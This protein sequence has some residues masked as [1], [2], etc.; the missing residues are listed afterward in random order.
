MR[1]AD[2]FWFRLGPAERAVIERNSTRRTYAAGDYLCHQG[3]RSRHVLVVRSGNVRVLS[4]APDGREVVVAVRVSGDVLGELAALDE[5]PRSASLQA[6][7]EVEVLAL[8]GARFALLC[9]TQPRLAWALL[10]VVAGRLRETGRQW[11]EFGGGGSAVRRVASLLLELAVLHG[12]TTSEGI[13]IVPPAT[14]EELASTAAMSRESY[15]RVLRELRER[16]LISTGRRRV[17][18]HQPEELRR[19]VR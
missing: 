2:G 6:L 16:G 12:K 19:L 5:G 10:G 9:Q 7:D 4:T 15:V 1:G 8:S 14:Q 13:E 18:L 3:D 11:A 17:I